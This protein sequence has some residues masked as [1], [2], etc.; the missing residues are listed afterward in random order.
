MANSAA[1]N[2]IEKLKRE[3]EGLNDRDRNNQDIINMLKEQNENLKKD[4]DLFKTDKSELQTKY[5]T[6]SSKYDESLRDLMGLR[7]EI[8][9][10]DQE[11]IELKVQL[12]KKINRIW[13]KE[14][15]LRETKKELESKTLELQ[16]VEKNPSPTGSLERETNYKP[17]F[18]WN[19]EN[20]P[21]IF[22]SYRIP[23]FGSYTPAFN[24]TNYPPIPPPYY[25]YQPTFQT[26]ITIPPIASPSFR[27]TSFS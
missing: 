13:S 11:K 18:S 27:V 12:D 15:E 2:S 19:W 24:P 9:H 4:L 6:L 21:Q 8:K 16:T 26:N 20:D 1:E 25:P 7:S 3:N 14:K 22:D 10:L 5:D 17:I 23:R